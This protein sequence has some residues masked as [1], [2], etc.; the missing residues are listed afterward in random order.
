MVATL[1]AHKD[2]A[3]LLRAMQKV[4]RAI[5]SA[6]LWLVGDGSLRKTLEGMKD[7]LGL[8]D[9]VQFLGSRRDVPALLGQSD[10]FVL[11]T[12]ADEGFGTVLVEAM[13]SG[14]PI[15]ASDVPACREVLQSGKWGRLV[16]AG[17]PEALATAL[18]EVLNAHRYMEPEERRAHVQQYMPSNMIAAYFASSS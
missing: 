13:A 2:H 7:S 11:S 4:V 6:R 17:E 8:A 16:P 10:V 9:S 14:L 15:V 1:E 3:T 12:T 5:P 18:V